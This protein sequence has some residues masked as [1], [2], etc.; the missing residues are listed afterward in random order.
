MKKLTILT[1]VLHS[2]LL[3]AG[4]DQPQ[5]LCPEEILPAGRECLDLTRVKNPHV[6]FPSELSSEEKKLWSGKWAAD[7][8]LCRHREILRREASYPGSFTPLQI[9]IAW[10]I[11]NGGENA[12]AK[13]S[14]MMK[15][16]RTHEIPPYVLLGALTQESLL[17]SL[18]ISPD[19]GNYSCGIAQLNIQEWCLG[20]NSLPAAE[21][22]KI[23]WPAISCSSVSSSMLKPFYDIARLK[24]N[25]RPEYRITATDFKD[26]SFEQVKSSFPAAP[27]SLQKQ[28]YS[29][30]HSFIRHCQDYELSISA[31][32]KTLR[33]LFVNFVPSHLRSHERYT[34][35]ETF[36]R[37]CKLP[38]QSAYY[39]LHTGW[40]LAVAMYNAGPRQMKL[41]EHYYHG[42]VPA[43]S[44]TDLIE[45]LHWGGEVRPGTNKV[46]YKGNDGKTY[47]QTWYKSCV[48]QRHVSRVI[49]HVSPA[50]APLARSLEQEPCGPKDVPLY[51][52]NASGV[53]Q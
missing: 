2:S 11:S 46:F 38:Y 8:K 52:K 31:K 43:L 36:K 32:A 9:Q 47:S 23:G 5:V 34:S 49:Q 22:A 44:P 40:L 45:A 14:A 50:G 33:H 15:A 12:E 39:P 20:I 37:Q 53:K 29:A 10:M 25:G 27:E 17:S 16:S 51:R 42:K 1:L 3:L 28:R 41:L 26:I 35:G 6:D 18:G 19:G 24:L 30:V 4:W 7:L 48:V 21:K 13:L